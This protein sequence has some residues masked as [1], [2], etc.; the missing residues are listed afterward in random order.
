MIEVQDDDLVI[1]TRVTK[2]F[3]TP[4]APYT[5]IRQWSRLEPRTHS[6]QCARTLV[7]QRR[8]RRRRAEHDL[9]RRP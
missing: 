5:A 4:A 8:R 9:R 7:H 3:Q 2:S 1:F 6:R